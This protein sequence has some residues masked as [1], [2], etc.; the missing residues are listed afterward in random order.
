MVLEPASH[1]EGSTNQRRGY[2]DQASG[3]ES[4]DERVALTEKRRAT[5]LQRG[6]VEPIRRPGRTFEELPERAGRL[7]QTSPVLFYPGTQ[8]PLDPRLVI[9]GHG[10]DGGVGDRIAHGRL[11]HVAVRQVRI[12]CAGV[13]ETGLVFDWD[14]FEGHQV[15]RETQ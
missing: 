2:P 9:V 11:F 3:E 8:Q 15:V 6:L 4:E 10:G 5:H 7:A 14:L 13:S 12:Q 1:K